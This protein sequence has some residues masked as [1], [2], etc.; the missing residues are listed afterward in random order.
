M[1]ILH[2]EQHEDFASDIH[3]LFDQ[4]NFNHAWESDQVI[5]QLDKLDEHYDAIVLETLMMIGDET[6]EYLKKHIVFNSNNMDT[7][8]I[9]YFYI[10]EKY[11]H[12]PIIIFAAKRRWD[13]KINLNDDTYWIEKPYN[14]RK[15]KLLSEIFKKI[16][17]ELPLRS[18]P[19]QM[20]TMEPY[21]Q[22]DLFPGRNKTMKNKDIIDQTNE[23][24]DGIFNYQQ[25]EINQ[26]SGRDHQKN[27]E[28]RLKA[29]EVAGEIMKAK[30]K[31]KDE[32]IP[33]I[34]ATLLKLAGRA[35]AQA[36]GWLGKKKETLVDENCEKPTD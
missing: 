8:E 5:Q 12:M 33:D 30:I 29:M 11:P 28:L 19:K 25:K 26:L 13:I 35:K 20:P 16:Q 23:L 2:I 32:L 36:E 4:Y 31:T 24:I 6:S 17:S 18:Q 1:N 22:R 10:R 7:G 14:D 34:E 15:L 27:F 21:P 9:L 3:F